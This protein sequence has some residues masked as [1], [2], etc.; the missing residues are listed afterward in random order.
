MRLRIRGSIPEKHQAKRG[1]LTF[2]VHQNLIAL[3]DIQAISVPT[4]RPK[5]LLFAFEC[6]AIERNAIFVGYSW[7]Q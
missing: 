6:E 7:L 1:G 2:R 4:S 5:R 3:V